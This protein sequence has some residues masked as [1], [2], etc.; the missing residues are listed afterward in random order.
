[1]IAQGWH[2]PG[3]GDDEGLLRRSNVH[4]VSCQSGVGMDD[5]MGSLMGLATD[6]GNK[7]RVA[8]RLTKYFV[9]R[10]PCLLP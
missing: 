4:L 5:L 7:V 10:C 9:M 1:M 8:I 2:R 6:N 3:K